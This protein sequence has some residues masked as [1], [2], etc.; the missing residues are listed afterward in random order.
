MEVVRQQLNVL[1]EHIAK[2]HTSQFDGMIPIYC[3]MKFPNE[4]L[5][6]KLQRGEFDVKEDDN[7]TRAKNNTNFAMSDKIITRIPVRIGRVYTSFFIDIF[8]SC[9]LGHDLFHK[10]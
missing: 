9:V 6:D 5:G 7:I 4:K 8:T 1:L 2:L 10:L 3:S